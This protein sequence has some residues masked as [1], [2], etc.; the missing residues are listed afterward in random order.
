[1]SDSLG[2]RVR[3][4]RQKQGLSQQ[5]LARSAECEQT[6]ISRIESREGYEPGT[7]T[8]FRV[9]KALGTSIDGLLEGVIDFTPQP[10]HK[11]GAP[12]EMVARMGEEIAVLHK[13]MGQVTDTL[14]QFGSVLKEI[15]SDVAELKTGR[16]PKALVRR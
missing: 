12:P 1:M 10:I 7:F 16:K 15:R 11:T 13:N 8:L 4:L 5:D 2:A 9:A 3:A 6:L 14:A